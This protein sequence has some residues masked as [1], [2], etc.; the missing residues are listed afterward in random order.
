M[1]KGKKTFPCGEQVTLKKAMDVACNSKSCEVEY[2]GSTIYLEKDALITYKPTC[3]NDPAGTCTSSEKQNNVIGD[4]TIKLCKNDDTPEKRNQMVTCAQDYKLY[5]KL[6]PDGDYCKDSNSEACYREYVYSC[7]Y[8]KAPGISASAGIVGSD[9]LGLINITGYDYGNVGLKGYFLSAGNTPSENYNWKSFDSNNKAT[10][11]Q[12]AGTYFVWAKNN[13]GIMSN[14]VLVKVYDADLST[15]MKAFGIV[16]ENSGD[17]LS[18]KQLD[19]KVANADQIVDAKYALLS[20]HLLADSNGMGYDQLTTAYEITTTSNKI[21]LYATLTSDDASYLE[22]YEPRTVDLD[23][24]KNSIIIGI[25]NKDGKQRFYTFIVNRVDDRNNDNTLSSIKLSK[26]KIN[27]DPYVT[28]YDVEISKNT[29]KVSINAELNGENAGFVVGYEPRTI[30]I[31][32]D[33]QSAVIK[34]MSDAGNVRSYVITFIKKDY[35][36]EPGNSAY[37]SSLTV[38]GTQLSFDRDVYEYTVTVPYETDRVP[39]YAFAE[40]EN[41]EVTIGDSTFL[42]VGTTLVEIEVKNGKNVKIYNLYIIRKEAGLDISNST[43]LGMLS[44]KGYDINFDPNVLDYTVKIKREKTLMIAATPESNRA[45]I[46]MYGNND[47]T[48]FSTVRVKVIAE[49]GLTQVYSID[50]KKDAYNK[51]LEIIVASVGCLIIVISGIIIISTRKKNK[52]KEYMEG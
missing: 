30:E 36:E 44:I 11:S 29:K 39:I 40:S 12:P 51:K 22:G 21:A 28:N 4:I 41:A 16:D 45:D 17:V 38:P 1:T 6:A 27:F 48:G 19:N 52:K 47:L 49:N 8:G 46:Y 3:S 37:L 33:K 2:K 50:I 13:K 20:N 14:S 31:T 25:V 15:T 23:Y 10:E 43:R 34:V 26:G 9:G 42:G 7:V 24:G 18:L 35:V 5:Y 32:E